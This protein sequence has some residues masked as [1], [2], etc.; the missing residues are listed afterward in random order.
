MLLSFLW[1]PKKAT[2]WTPPRCVCNQIE[3]RVKLACALR[4]EIANWATPLTMWEELQKPKKLVP[5]ETPKSPQFIDTTINT[6][7]ENA[8]KSVLAT[9]WE[10]A[11]YAEG[12]PSRLHICRH[13]GCALPIENTFGICTLCVAKKNYRYV[14]RTAGTPYAY[15]LANTEIQDEFRFKE[16]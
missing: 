9:G 3:T 16:D 14:H 5:K 12:M 1:R 8:Y 6:Y 13:C 7:F 11:I 15:Y 4:D 10:P 2:L